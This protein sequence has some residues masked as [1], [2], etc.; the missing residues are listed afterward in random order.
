MKTDINKSK[1]HNEFGRKILTIIAQVHPYVKH[2][3]YTAETRGIIAHNMFTSTGIIDDS[4]VKLYENY[5]GKLTDP[6]EIKLKLFS[7]ASERLTKI[8]K[9]ESQYKGSLSTSQIL[10]AELK[11]LEEKYEVDIDNDM[12]MEDELEDIS[13]KQD[14]FKKLEFLYNDAEKNII[15][16]LEIDNSRI[17]V[18]DDKRKAFNYIYSW[19]PLKTSNIL[20]LFVF[21]KLS[22]KEIA[23]IKGVQEIEIRKI[24]QSVS[25]TFRKNIV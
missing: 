21:G 25:K 3:L 1:Q 20:D 16:S 24:I 2:R 7:L 6:N 23:T 14:G 13:Y 12:L 8:I 10:D 19:L 18:A 17:E 9:K 15:S 22:Y 4:I 11:Q 5:E